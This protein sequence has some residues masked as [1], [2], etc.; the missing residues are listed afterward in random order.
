MAKN[1]IWC[2]Y[3][4]AGQKSSAVVRDDHLDTGNPDTIYLFNMARNEII[5]YN[6]AIVEPKLREFTADE[7]EVASELKA[8]YLRARKQFKV[9]TER[10]MPTTSRTTRPAQEGK[11][12]EDDDSFS[13]SEPEFESVL[14]DDWDAGDD[15]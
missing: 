4:E 5:P 7:E 3:L 13:S 12:P 14:D 11:L 10:P 6:R 15:D 9:R 2:G 8:A 1:S